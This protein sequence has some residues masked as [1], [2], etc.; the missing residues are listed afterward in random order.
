M[1]R[2]SDVESGSPTGGPLSAEDWAAQEP[3]PECGGRPGYNP[4]TGMLLRIR[5]PNGEF[6]EGHTYQCQLRRQE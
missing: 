5:L 6:V 2:R 1:P 4:S 3:C